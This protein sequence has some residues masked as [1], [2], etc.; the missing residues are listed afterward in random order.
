MHRPTMRAKR[1]IQERLGDPNARTPRDI[2]VEWLA[3]KAAD[4]RLALDPFD[5]SLVILDASPN[6]K[7]WGYRTLEL[8]GF[9]E[10]R[11]DQP[12]GRQR[13]TACLEGS[14][15]H[16]LGFDKADAPVAPDVPLASRGVDSVEPLIRFGVDYAEVAR[17]IFMPSAPALTLIESAD[18]KVVR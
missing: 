17:D 3:L 1:A 13:I 5:R 10:S 14:V 9:V 12:D 4:G 2:A 18:D 15:M 7:T 6:E 16:Q 11:F 8:C